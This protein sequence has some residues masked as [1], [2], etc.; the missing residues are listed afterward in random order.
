MTIESANTPHIA[1]LKGQA[2]PAVVRSVQ[3]ASRRTGVDFA[4]LLEKAAVESSFD[5]RAR[6]ETSSAAGLFQ[7]DDHTWL[8]MVRDHG[9][10]YGLGNYAAALKQGEVDA[11]TRKDILAYRDDPRLSAAMAAEYARANQDRLEAALGREVTSTELYLAH[12]LGGGGAERFLRQLDSDPTAPAAELLPRA[13]AANEPVFYA[14]GQARSVQ[15][16]YNHFAARFAGPE[17]GRAG[18]G[19]GQ[20]APAE[21]VPANRNAA[22]SFAFHGS[23]NGRPIP[24]SHPA[25][26]A[27]LA[28]QA[29][30]ISA[31]LDPLSVDKDAIL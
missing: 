29:M 19:Q 11:G 9:H 18:A 15:D 30:L 28:L 26:P 4:Y 31:A 14:N 2:P 6:A 24:P 3:A 23:S 22:A 12:F 7:F 5:T 27:P 16:V 10:K 20:S 13:A 8:K 1:A 25:D 17:K 21:S